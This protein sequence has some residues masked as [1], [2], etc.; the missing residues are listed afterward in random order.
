MG[1]VEV[2]GFPA[3]FLRRAVAAVYFA[4]VDIAKKQ[5]E[6]CIVNADGEQVLSMPVTNSV[7]GAERLLRAIHGLIGPDPGLVTFCMEATGHYWLAFY[8]FL[9]E[10]GYTVH[11][12]NPIQSDAARDL[13]IRKN[14]TDRKDAY[15]LADLLRMNKTQPTSMASEPVLRLQTLSR[16]RFAFVDQ[17]SNLKQR[18]LGILDR[19]FPEYPQCFSDVFIKAS[20]ELLKTFSTPEELAEVDL[21]ELA[22][23]LTAHSRGRL[24]A[25]RARQVQSYA[26]STFGI[27]IAVDAFAL[28]LKLLLDQI[29]FIENQIS[30]I[31]QAI[32]EAMAELAA[33]NQ[34]TDLPEGVYHVIETI[35]GIGRILAAAIIGETGDIGRFVSAR[36]YVAFAGLD[37]TVRESGQFAG[38]RNRMSKRGSPYL[39][40]AIWLA[41]VNARRLNPELRSYYE[42]KRAQG[43][44][45][46]VATGAV[47]RRLAHL[48]HA[49][50]RDQRAFDPDFRWTPPGAE[51]NT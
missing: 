42:A 50:W 38:T 37:A 44:H 29:E 10:R 12:V 26:R 34:S 39:Q 23:F 28:E 4:G 41:A 2:C 43:K 11:V 35:P 47:A 18:V 1:R 17:V 8:S 5:H 31:E 27:S 48:I 6:V 45:A 30:A 3:Y 19:I 21:S 49:I 51:P 13:Y 20:R 33:M 22:E 7:A 9:T 15:I 14:K 25:E 36:K 46:N 16:T 40:R 32:E 24:G